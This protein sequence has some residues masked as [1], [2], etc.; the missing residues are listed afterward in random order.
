MELQKHFVTFIDILGFAKYVKDNTITPDRPLELLKQFIDISRQFNIKDN[1]KITAFSDNIVISMLA[2]EKDPPFN[3]DPEYWNFLAYINYFQMSI[4]TFI[5]I[6]PIRGGI[7]YGN[8]Y[9]NGSEILFGEAMIEAY[10]LERL[11]AFFPRIVVNPKFL[12]PNA[13]LA[14][15]K[16]LYSMELPIN[17]PKTDSE[18]L[19]RYYPVK[20]DC[21]GI[22]FCNYLSALYLIDKRWAEY[23][24]DAL[25]K[26]K[27][28]VLS[29]LQAANDL[30]VF[31]KYTW[32][33]SYHN[34]FCKP[35]KE[36]QKYIIPDC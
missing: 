19:L 1:L 11:H 14:A 35:F 2:K 15:H 10:D 13:Y 20:Y 32:M 12:E 8:F 3:Y 22:L 7:T 18:Q 29:N 24:E 25:N 34:W 36:F 30:N 5:G 17:I 28:F 4:I 21:D 31:R 6:L 23:S 26:H 27:Y 33:K 9:H 16:K